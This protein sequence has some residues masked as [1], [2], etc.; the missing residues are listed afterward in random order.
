MIIETHYNRI[1]RVTYTFD[2]ADIKTALE[3]YA[4]IKYKAGQTVTM[5]IHESD[6]YKTTVVLT[7]AFEMPQEQP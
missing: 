6:D 1:E 7:V 3:Q 4:K 5:E 2:E